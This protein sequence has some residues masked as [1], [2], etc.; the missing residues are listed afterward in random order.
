MKSYKEVTIPKDPVREALQLART[1]LKGK[2]KAK[3]LAEVEARVA[4]LEGVITNILERL[5]LG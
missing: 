5:N 1:A 4:E 2:P 3:G